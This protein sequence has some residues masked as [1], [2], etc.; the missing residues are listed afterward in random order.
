MNIQERYSS[1]ICFNHAVACMGIDSKM[2][3]CGNMRSSV[4]SGLNM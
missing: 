2:L 4:D 1:G 3:C